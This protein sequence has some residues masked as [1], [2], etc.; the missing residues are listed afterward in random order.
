MT[1]FAKQVLVCVRVSLRTRLVQKSSIT[2]ELVQCDCQN[3][4]FLLTT[5]FQMYIRNKKE[6]ILT[7]I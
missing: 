6:P 2:Y 4:S 7:D 5:V 3:A 1:T